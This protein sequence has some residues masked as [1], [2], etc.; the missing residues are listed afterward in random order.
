[1]RMPARPARFFVRVSLTA[2]T[3][4]VI[5]AIVIQDHTSALPLGLFNTGAT[6]FARFADACLLLALTALT[7]QIV[8]LIS[9]RLARVGGA[10]RGIGR[11]RRDLAGRVDGSACQKAGRGPTLDP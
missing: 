4:C 3:A 11:S 2:V 9:G 8:E 6:T 7:V 1:M 5:A 10:I